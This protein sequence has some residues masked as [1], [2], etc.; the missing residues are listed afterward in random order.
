MELRKSD[1]T[2][3][4]NL[5]QIAGR[6]A[7]LGGWSITLPEWD[8]T[9]TDENCAIHEV[10]PGYKPSLSEGIGYFPEEYRN[11]VRKAVEKCA[12]DGISYD[13][14]LPKYTAKG[15]LIW[16]RSI[17]EAIYDEGGKIVG[18]QGAFQDITA[19]K[20]I[21]QQLL[22]SREQYRQIVDLASDLIYKIDNCGEFTYVNPSVLKTLNYSADELLGFRYTKV[23]HKKFRWQLRE[24]FREQLAQRTPTTY[25]EF[26]VL[27][28]EG[29]E[30]WVGQHAQLIYHDEIVVGL[31]AISRDITQKKHTEAELRQ[32]S[33]TDELTGLYNRR[34]F[35][36]LA[37]HQLRLAANKK[38]GNKLLVIYIDLDEL[39]YI[40]DTF[41]H[42]EGSNAIIST[43]KLLK[44]SF[45]QTD[46]IARFGGDEFVVMANETSEE[47]TGMILGRMQVIF[48]K[49]N[50][51]RRHP[52]ELLF[53]YGVA[54]FESHDPVKIEELLK[55]ADENMYI[56]KKERKNSRR[57]KRQFV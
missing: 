17:G 55:K 54:K 40:N 29:K 28:K 37:E 11:E 35:L 41:G 38:N 8:L 26:V 49:Y 18:L 25:S 2:N 3:Q 13:F 51:L 22:E 57:L 10:P 21:E 5:S 14:E 46:L 33:L 19:Q 30:V 20:K 42:D 45:R 1:L 56:H 53:S 34:G 23:V 24:T 32:L 15:N 44:E 4:S 9:W 47:N 16:V 31:Q 6:I 7:K 39:K 43:A 27:N 36:A 12:T 50:L 48:E 52:F